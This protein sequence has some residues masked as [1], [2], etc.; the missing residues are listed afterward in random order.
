MGWTALCGSDSRWAP[1]RPRG[2]PAIAP[3][4]PRTPSLSQPL[5][6]AALPAFH[7][8]LTMSRN[9]CISDTQTCVRRWAPTRRHPELSPF[10]PDPSPLLPCPPARLVPGV[11]LR[12]SARSTLSGSVG[13]EA[14]WGVVSMLSYLSFVGKLKGDAAAG[15]DDW[16]TCA[17]VRPCA[18]QALVKRVSIRGCKLTLTRCLSRPHRTR[19]DPITRR[20]FSSLSP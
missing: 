17:P 9:K 20:R 2:L 4:R 8:L 16:L 14:L 1:S 12:T 11:S 10:P 13:A 15:R 3:P 7:C 6:A 19:Q 5:G 18:R